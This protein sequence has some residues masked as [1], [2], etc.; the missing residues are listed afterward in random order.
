MVWGLRDRSRG[1]SSSSSTDTPARAGILPPGHAGRQG[2]HCSASGLWS[3]CNGAS[4][5]KRIGSSQS[6]TMT[7]AGAG[8]TEPGSRRSDSRGSSCCHHLSLPHWGSCPSTS[9]WASRL[10]GACCVFPPLQTPQHSK[11]L[12]T[13]N[14]VVLS[15]QKKKENNP[16]EMMKSRQFELR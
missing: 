7:L 12:N 5:M 8:P 13:C 1:S 3:R 6:S 9:P 15:T 10:D 11:P 14:K 2:P 4:W 16:Y